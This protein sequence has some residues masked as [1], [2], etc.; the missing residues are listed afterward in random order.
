M[1]IETL[2]HNTWAKTYLIVDEKSRKAAIIDSVFGRH[3]QDL[4]YIKQ[5][6]LKLIYAIATHTHADHVTAC[7]E[8]REKT[9]CDYIMYHN[10]ISMGVNKYVQ[11]GE[12]SILGAIP[13]T[14]H[15]AP[16][17]TNDS[18]IIEAGSNLFTG[19]FLFTGQ[20]GV[21]RDDLPSGRPEIH[22]ESL[23]IL[24]KFKDDVMIYTG[25]DPPDIKMQTL[26]WNRN[27]NPVLNFRT[28]DE[29]ISWQ[30]NQWEV[31]GDVKKIKTALP[32]NVFADKNIDGK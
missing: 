2:H 30:K 16:G 11:N 17:H 14:F 10:T 24:N 6:N 27:N 13:I 8:L 28:Y 31:L 29:Y 9:E 5:N 23:R 15:F 21:G 3:E 4:D 22:W 12:I 18:M 19:D 1:L 20:A 32:A 7:F 26:G 25:H